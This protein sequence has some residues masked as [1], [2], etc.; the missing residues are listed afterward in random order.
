M[1]AEALS[2]ADDMLRSFFERWQR[3]EEEKQALSGDLKE[4]FAEMKGGGFDTKAARAV[5][6]DEN[7][8]ANED[9]AD[10]ADRT[11]FEAMCELY[12]AS[13]KRPRAGRARESAINPPHG[14]ASGWG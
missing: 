4:L 8:L 7:K 2:V 12:R 5:F 14:T 6:R 13:L 3:L 11:E 9:A 10:K 1:S